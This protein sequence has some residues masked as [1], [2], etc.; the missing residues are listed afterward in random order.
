MKLKPSQNEGMYICN[1]ITEELVSF[2]VVI[3]VKMEVT[4]QIRG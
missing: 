4:V 3:A 2:V 1:E